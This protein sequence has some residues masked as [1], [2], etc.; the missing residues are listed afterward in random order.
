MARRQALLLVVAML[1]LITAVT[2]SG[3]TAA[4]TEPSSEMT[5]SLQTF[6]ID[7]FT[8]KVSFKLS[9]GIEVLLL[10]GSFK[11]VYYYQH[12]QPTI[13]KHHISVLIGFYYPKSALGR[14][15][16]RSAEVDSFAFY[17]MWSGFDGETYDW[18]D[19]EPALELND[20]LIDGQMI[21]AQPMI[22]NKPLSRYLPSFGGIFVFKGLTIHLRDSSSMEISEKPITIELKKQSSK[23]TPEGSLHAMNAN[24][25]YE[26]SVRMMSLTLPSGSTSVL[27][28]IDLVVAVSL[29]GVSGAAVTIFIL[30]RTNR[31]HISLDRVRDAFQQQQQQPDE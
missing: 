16:I 26:T 12:H 2:P 19:T 22:T 9:D 5:P 13:S 17:P 24:L 15:L 29:A 31:I 25:S 21:A 18:L 3:A 1:L 6:T 8:Y 28:A 14:T 11:L 30:H 4:R 27:L 7:E 10:R 23:S 20:T